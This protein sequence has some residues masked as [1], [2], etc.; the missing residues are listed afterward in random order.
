MASKLVASLKKN[1]ALA[2]LVANEVVKDEFVSTNCIPVNL[3]LSGKIKGGIKK[4][5]ISQICADSGWGKSMIGLNVLK[6]AQQQGFDCVVI[7]TEKAFNRDL[8]ASL[9]INVNDIAIFESSLVPELKQIVANINNGL[10]RAE[11]RNVFI[12]LDSWG[13]IVE[14]QVL[15]KAAEASTAVNMS[16][17]RF[18]NELATVLSCYANTVLVLNHVYA[19]LQQYGDAYAIPGGKK[20][21]FLS[22]AIMMASSA[23]KAKD[24]DGAI[25]GKIITASVKKGRAA[26]EFAKTKFLIEHSG[27]INPYYGLL[28]DAIAAG[29]VFKPKAGRYARTDYDVDQTTGEVTRQWKE[30]ELYCAKFWIPLYKDEK[31]NKYVE[32]K[33]AFEDEEL[34][35][36]TQD[37][38]AMINGEA[39]IPDETKLVAESETEENMTLDV[40][41]DDEE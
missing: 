13:P 17:A 30:D 7:D 41:N 40:S 2:E 9:G 11:Q 38:L 26:K 8:A 19:T 1:K 31:F 21:Y 39:E 22:D 12:L 34:I 36:A 14:Q 24:K 27:G 28:D 5:K 18:K 4:G 37:V 15:D 6:A 35:S 10:S 23:A 3:L 20:L 29:V 25:Y 32:Q 33:F 16:G